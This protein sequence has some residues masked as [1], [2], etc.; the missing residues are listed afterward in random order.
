MPLPLTFPSGVSNESSCQSHPA[1]AVRQLPAMH[2]VVLDR[3]VSVSVAVILIVF[4]P[5]SLSWQRPAINNE[6]CP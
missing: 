6:A 5:S 2:S 1:R 3:S 4:T